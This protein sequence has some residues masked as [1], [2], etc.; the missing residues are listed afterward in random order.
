LRGDFAGMPFAQPAA[1]D[2]AQAAGSA[3]TGLQ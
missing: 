1:R 2:A 3:A